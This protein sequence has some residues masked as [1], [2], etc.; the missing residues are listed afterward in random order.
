MSE[1]I[2]N[3]ILNRIQELHREQTVTRSMIDRDRRS[4]EKQRRV[5][6]ETEARIARAEGRDPELD[7]LIAFAKSHG[8]EVPQY[9]PWLNDLLEE[10]E[11]YGETP[12]EEEVRKILADFPEFRDLPI[13]GAANKIMAIHE[14]GSTN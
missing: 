5:L 14:S 8:W 11:E 13:R 4:L 1:A 12:E 2:K 7:E 10:I 6:A 3:L 9:D